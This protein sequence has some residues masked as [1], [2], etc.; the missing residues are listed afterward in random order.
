MKRNL[1]L[2]DVREID[3]GDAVIQLSKAM[4]IVGKG[5]LASTTDN[6]SS[7]RI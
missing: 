2:A 1:S 3:V 5:I 7:G 6:L 4:T